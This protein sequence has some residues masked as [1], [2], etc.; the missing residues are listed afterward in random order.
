MRVSCPRSAETTCSRRRP[1]SR[2]HHS[3][4]RKVPQRSIGSSRIVAGETI[5]QLC[6]PFRKPA[7]RRSEEHTSE[8]QSQFHLVC[9]L[10]LEKKKNKQIKKSFKE[11]K[12][13]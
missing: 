13:T 9:R 11:I 7:V 5:A 1:P 6:R 12:N 2:H 10:L 8:L 3:P 4:A